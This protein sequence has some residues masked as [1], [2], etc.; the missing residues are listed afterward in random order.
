MVTL[1]LKCNLGLVKQKKTGKKY[2]LQEMCRYVWKIERTELLT[3]F[4]HFK[5]GNFQF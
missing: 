3:K 5:N 2:F 1:Q 4:N